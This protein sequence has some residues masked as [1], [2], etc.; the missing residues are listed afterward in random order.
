MTRPEATRVYMRPDRNLAME[1][2]TEAGAIAAG[3]RVGRGD[4]E[5]R[6]VQSRLSARIKGGS[7]RK[8][9]PQ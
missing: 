1:P 3:R 8:S 9:L 2:D 6:R 4:K 5:G 7:Q